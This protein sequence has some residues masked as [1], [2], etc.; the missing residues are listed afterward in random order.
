MFHKTAKL[1]D[2]QTYVTM[3]AKQSMRPF[4]YYTG[5]APSGSNFETCTVFPGGCMGYNMPG[6]AVDAYNSSILYGKPGFTRVA[7]SASTELFGGPF[8]ARGEGIL[9]NPDG[10]S[11]AWTP[12]GGY[13]KHCAKRL[14]EI[15]YIPF[16]ME[17]Q[18]VPN[19]SDDAFD[20][21]GG[22]STRMGVQYISSC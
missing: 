11:A 16:S 6:K 14:S 2:D 5:Y 3:H 4:D 21:R 18:G 15:S 22:V 9:K 13:E 7:P 1:V 19:S 8:K 17:C 20:K 10:L 12:K